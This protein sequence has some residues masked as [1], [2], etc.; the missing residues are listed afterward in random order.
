M[1]YFILFFAVGY[2]FNGL[3]KLVRGGKKDE[4]SIPLT[5]GKSSSV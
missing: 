1:V 5:E 2:E 3:Q 4:N